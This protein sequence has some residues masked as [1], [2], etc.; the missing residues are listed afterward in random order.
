MRLSL[1]VTQTEKKDNNAVPQSWWRGLILLCE[2][3]KGQVDAIRG[4]KL[5]QANVVGDK[6]SDSTHGTTSFSSSAK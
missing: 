3:S 1:V 2:L 5:G 4:K 6:C